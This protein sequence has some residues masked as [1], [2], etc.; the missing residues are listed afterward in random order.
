M[1]NKL[2]RMNLKV[3]QKLTI[4]VK[5]VFHELTDNEWLVIITPFSDSILPKHMNTHVIT[6][7]LVV[8]NKTNSRNYVID[9]VHTP[10]R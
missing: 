9:A 2:I 3:K 6:G 7:N 4:S 5:D 1:R 10:K 8:A